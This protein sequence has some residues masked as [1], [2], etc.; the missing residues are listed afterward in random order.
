MAGSCASP[1]AVEIRDFQLISFTG[2]AF[3]GQLV[4]T[5][6]SVQEKP[7][8]SFSVQL[9]P[10]GDAQKFLLYNNGGVVE[11]RFLVSDTAQSGRFVIRYEGEPIL[12]TTMR[13]MVASCM[14]TT[15]T[16]V[17]GSRIDGPDKET[18]P[19]AFEDWVFHQ[20]GVEHPLR[21]HGKSLVL[22]IAIGWGFLTVFAPEEG[23]HYAMIRDSLQLTQPDIRYDWLANSRVITLTGLEW[24]NGEEPYLT[25]VAEGTFDTTTATFLDG[26]FYAGK[27]AGGP[28]SATLTLDDHN[29][30]LSTMNI[31]EP[32]E[33]PEPY[34]Y[35]EPLGRYRWVRYRG[36]TVVKDA[37]RS[38]GSGPI[39]VRSDTFFID[40]P[41]LDALNEPYGN[42][43]GW[44][45]RQGN[46]VSLSLSASVRP[47]MRDGDLT[48][49]NT[50]VDL[51]DHPLSESSSSRFVVEY[52]T[53]DPIQSG[54]M[55][56]STY[57]RHS[58]NTG[59]WDEWSNAIERVGTPT[60]TSL[61]ITVDLTP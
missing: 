28:Y 36:D 13:V 27:I 38:R 2:D 32:P 1:D 18:C 22:P 52:S 41:C 12:D 21:E 35:I 40:A 51:A 20:H 15:R 19:A 23:R 26:A 4:I 37:A 42:V 33:P 61:R 16:A 43:R 58:S 31:P 56:L 39:T 25:L 46:T 54:V 9:G 11:I 45:V 14:P 6:F 48:S 24:I 17:L 3:L 10:R 47:Y 57:Y 34:V 44:I 7:S 49:H 29:V 53:G 30:S 5:E 59:S 8:G 50:R 55:R 60:A